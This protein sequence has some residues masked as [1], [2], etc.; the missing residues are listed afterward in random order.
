MLGYEREVSLS[1]LQAFL[2][3]LSV[4][5][6][7]YSGRSMLGYARE[8]SLSFLQ[9][10]LVCLRGLLSVVSCGILMILRPVLSNASDSC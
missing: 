8:T 6:G 3:C 10:L 7:V 4:F 2:V 1:F 9:A 5:F